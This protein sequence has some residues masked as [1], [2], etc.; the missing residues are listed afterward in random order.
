MT[1]IVRNDTATISTI[2]RSIDIRGQVQDVRFRPAKFQRAV[3]TEVGI[4]FDSGICPDCL[5]EICDPQN[6]RFR[7]AFTSCINC[8]PRYS[9]IRQLPYDRAHTTISRF[10]MCPECQAEYNDPLDRL[11][12]FK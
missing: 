1:D 6:R 2:R 4:P 3:N 7:Y 10:P 12:P 11:S 8:G 9:I 5:H